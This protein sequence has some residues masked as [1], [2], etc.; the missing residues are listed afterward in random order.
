MNWRKF[1]FTSHKGKKV[2]FILLHGAWYTSKC[3][4]YVAEQLEKEGHKVECPDFPYYT[5]N[6]AKESTRKDFIH[7]TIAPLLDQIIGITGRKPILVGH[8]LA[9]TII[10]E[11]AGEYPDKVD[12]LVFLAGFMLPRGVSVLDLRKYRNQ[13]DVFRKGVGAIIHANKVNGR[14]N[15][16]TLDK[17]TAIERFCQDCSPAEQEKF[18]EMIV[19]DMPEEPIRSKV[20]WQSDNIK[21]PKIYIKTLYDRDLSIE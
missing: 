6:S 11:T 16:A 12:S 4:R 5:E 17:A 1:S 18:M 14:L 19:W 8:S 15:V 21:V 10:S 2:P 13:Q 9:G 7:T 3:W 20:A